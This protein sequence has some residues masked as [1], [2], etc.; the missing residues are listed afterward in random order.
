M[1]RYAPTRSLVNS[2]PDF[3]NGLT[4]SNGLTSNSGEVLLTQNSDQYGT[5]LLRMQNRTGTN[6]IILDASLAQSGIDLMDMAFRS[7]HATYGLQQQ[8]IRMEGRSSALARTGGYGNEI[9]IGTGVRFC[10]PGGFIGPTTGLIATLVAGSFTVVLTTGSTATLVVGQGFSK[11]AGSGVL[12]AG[13]ITEIDPANTTTFTVSVAH[14]TSGPITFTAVAP[15]HTIESMGTSSS[16]DFNT[17]LGTSGVTYAVGSSISPTSNGSTLG[18]SGSILKY[19]PSHW[20]MVINSGGTTIRGGTASTSTTT[21]TLVVGGGVGISGSANVGGSLTL[22]GAAGFNPGLQIYSNGGTGG[23][24]ISLVQGYSTVDDQ[25]A[26]L[27]NRANAAFHFGTANST[28]MT[29]LPTGNVVI[30]SGEGTATLAGNTL[31][32]PSAVGT[33]IAGGSLTIA[34]GASTGSGLGG[35]IIFQTASAGSTGTAVNALVERMRIIT[36]G[37]VGIGTTTPGAL[38]DIQGTSESLYLLRAN[39]AN[40]NAPNLRIRKS[41]GTSASKSLIVNGDYLGHITWEGYDGVNFIEGAGIY[42]ISN[43]TVAV[44][45]IPSD[46][47]FYTNPGGVS[48]G[49]ERMRITAAGNLYLGTTSPGTARDFVL[50]KTTVGGTVFAIRNLSTSLSS[51]SAFLMGNSTQENMFVIFT[52][53]TGRTA[54]GGVNTTTIR[55]DSGNLRINTAGTLQ[56]GLATAPT[57]GQV[58]AATD[59]SGTLGWSS[60]TTYYRQFMFTS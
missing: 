19:F 5:N 37:N 9:Q 41:R 2:T 45:S 31:R 56:I 27:W 26:Y 25:I 59:T 49:L 52:N 35:S 11:T 50:E 40:S 33:D 58:L 53:S 22:Q 21:G 28:K 43:G 20:H 18:G 6:G 57:V 55:T 44:G 38:L 29:L 14:V 3:P 30:G 60:G 23:S 32:G 7:A 51:Y 4:F 13:A 48:Q 10:K 46:L 24:Q 39:G 36:S 17:W 15:N 54:D 1:T 34:G 47:A 16:S 8:Q 12:G 42:G